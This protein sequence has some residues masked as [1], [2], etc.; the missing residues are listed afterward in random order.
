MNHEHSLTSLQ[1]KRGRE[2][3]RAREVFNFSFG[4]PGKMKFSSDLEPAENS[5]FSR[6][7]LCCCCCCCCLLF[8]CMCQPPVVGKLSGD[9]KSGSNFQFAAACFQSNRLQGLPEPIRADQSEASKLVSL[10]AILA[11]GEKFPKSKQA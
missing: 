2:R 8:D 3:A 7:Q 5:Q 9:R 11:A 10:L 1:V 4:E 6:A